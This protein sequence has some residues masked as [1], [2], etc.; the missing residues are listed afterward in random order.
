MK[1]Q[2]MYIIRTQE[3]ILIAELS[4]DIAQKVIKQCKGHFRPLKYEGKP[5]KTAFQ[6][7]ENSRWG[8]PGFSLFLFAGYVLIPD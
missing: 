8:F 3:G 7:D 6:L 2:G 4:N 5:E 1:D